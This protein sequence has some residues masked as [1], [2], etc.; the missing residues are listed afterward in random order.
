M[1]PNKPLLTFIATVAMF[2]TVA[3][4]AAQTPSPD[5]AQITL[6]AADIQPDGRITF[7]GQGFSGGEQTALTIED[8]QG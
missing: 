3:P 4:V 5:Q 6:Q 2:S 7:S 1:S 8:D